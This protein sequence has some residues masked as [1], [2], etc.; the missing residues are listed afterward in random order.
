M[1]LSRGGVF[2]KM[3]NP[4]RPGT[5]VKM[6][7]Q[8]PGDEQIVGPGR[9]VWRR[10]SVSDEYG[11][12]GMGVKFLKLSAESQKLLDKVLDGADGE[13]VAATAE[14]GKPVDKP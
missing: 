12:S 10:E 5:L 11:P 7:I 14:S 3:V 13:M 2:V 9:V 1:N 4:Y 8:V 6:Q